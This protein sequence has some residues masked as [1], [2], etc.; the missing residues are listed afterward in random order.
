MDQ[1]VEVQIIDL[2]GNQR[3][4]LVISQYCNISDCKRLLKLDADFILLNGDRVVKETEE[5]RTCERQ[6]ENLILTLFKIKRNL[7]KLN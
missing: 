4:S 7:Q 6:T 2:G 3:D 5:I 1:T